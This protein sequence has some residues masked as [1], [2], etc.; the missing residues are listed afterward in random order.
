MVRITP[1]TVVRFDLRL[2]GDSP[3][4]AG[5]IREAL[6]HAAEAARTLLKVSAHEF[7]SSLDDVLA[8]LPGARVDVLPAPMPRALS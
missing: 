3:A 6:V 7:V 5:Q 2:R 1:T 4:I 8:Q